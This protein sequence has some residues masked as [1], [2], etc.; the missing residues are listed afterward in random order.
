[1]LWN[2]NKPCIP[3]LAGDAWL[4]GRKKTEYRSIGAHSHFWIAYICCST[5]AQATSVPTAALPTCV[6]SALVFCEKAQAF[7]M[8][9]IYLHRERQISLW[10][11]PGVNTVH[12]PCDIFRQFCRTM[13]R[14]LGTR[15]QPVLLTPAYIAPVPVTWTHLE[16]DFNP[17]IAEIPETWEQCSAQNSNCRVL[18]KKRLKRRTNNNSLP[19]YIA[20]Q[21]T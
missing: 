13:V 1:M 14:T 19:R 21:A 18:K 17:L 15:C 20:G 6:Y 2:S 11:W 7:K 5:H 10:K 16:A 12:V 3:G 8:P 9:G 4:F